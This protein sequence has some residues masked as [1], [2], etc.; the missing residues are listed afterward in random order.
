MRRD[1]YYE[2]TCGHRY[3][4]YQS[5]TIPNSHGYQSGN[6][7]PDPVRQ[8]HI[9]TLHREHQ[10][11]AIIG[12]GWAPSEGLASPTRLWHVWCPDAGARVEA[13]AVSLARSA[14][15]NFHLL[16]EASQAKWLAKAEERL[17]SADCA[18]R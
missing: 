13:V 3:E 2:C 9:A 7:V 1:R 15:E 12:A 8:D 4:Q 10:A 18:A 16:D 14:K 11:T 6:K 5:A 17:E